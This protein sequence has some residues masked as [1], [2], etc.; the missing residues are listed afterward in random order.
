M[1]KAVT[2]TKLI[3]VIALMTILIHQAHAGKLAFKDEFDGPAGSRPDPA[4]W[5]AETGGAGW[6]NR[7]LQYYRDSVENAYLD[8]KGILVIKAIK[9][10]DPALSCWYGPC[11]Y[12]SARL[13]TKGKFDLK[14]GRFEARIKVPRGQGVW[15]AFW[16]LGNDIDTVGWPKCGE[17]DIMENIGREPSSVHGTVHGPG[18]SGSKGIGGAFSF[19][20]NSIF[21][22]AFHIYTVE[23]TAKEIRWYVDD[24]K[25]KT[26]KSKDLPSGSKW[27]FDHP[28]FMILNFAVGGEWPGVPDDTTEFPQAMQV[29]YVRVY[30]F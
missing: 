4:R 29:D 8:G 25:F 14:Y 27:V 20:N 1:D 6:G 30:K 21:A 7:E 2:T 17:I 10:S 9:M 16:M 26:L 12:T 11:G 18:Y 24:I 28:F 22:D 19:K 23:W 15:P 5:T 3:S 13:V